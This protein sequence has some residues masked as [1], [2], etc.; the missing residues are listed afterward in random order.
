MRY[1]HP[2]QAHERFGAS[3]CYRFFA[4]GAELRKTESWAIHAHPDGERFIRVDADARAEEGKSILAE[5]LMS[6][7]DKLVRLD[8]RYENAQF[9]GGVKTLR[10]TY[11]ISDDRLQ[12][13]YSMNGAERKY[14]EAA[15]PPDSL[16][17]VPLL[18][19]RG[20][21]IAKIAARVGSEMAIYVPM[22]DHAQLFPGVLREVRSPVEYMGE[23]ALYLG[24]REVP[25]R[26]FRYVDKAAMYWID[27]YDIIIKRVSG[28]KQRE[29]KVE[30]SNYAAPAA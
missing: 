10:A 23:E 30:I 20:S 26:R 7:D 19:F 8:I 5:A 24:E 11:Q 25:T 15:L 18:V 17:D 4:N 22:F 9:E 28:Y 29:F 1:L 27:Q 14:I 16:V 21:A 12:V 2:V 3:G 6:Y 13:G